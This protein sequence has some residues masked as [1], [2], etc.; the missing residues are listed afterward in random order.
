MASRKSRQLFEIDSYTDILMLDLWFHRV[1]ELA[2]YLA[3]LA[4]ALRVLS[5]RRRPTGSD[6]FCRGSG[7]LRN[8]L[9]GSD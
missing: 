2:S 9:F 3:K 5:A 6:R 8:S 7:V 4:A 1:L